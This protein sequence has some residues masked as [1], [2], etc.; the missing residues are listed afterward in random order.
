[1]IHIPLQIQT[2]MARVSLLSTNLIYAVILYAL[3]VH[4]LYGY[5]ASAHPVI[6]EYLL[7][8]Y[9]KQI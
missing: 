6:M 5:C 8:A 4:R 2:Q 7:S 1:M 3:F 9:N